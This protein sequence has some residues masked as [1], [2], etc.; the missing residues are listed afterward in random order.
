MS[1]MRREVL[2]CDYELGLDEGGNPLGLA[3]C[4]GLHK[5]GLP[6]DVALLVMEFAETRHRM[7]YRRDFYEEFT[8]LCNAVLVEVSHSIKE[9]AAYEHDLCRLAP[10]IVQLTCPTELPILSSLPSDRVCKSLERAVLRAP[11]L[12]A[13]PARNQIRTNQSRRNYSIH[14]EYDME[15]VDAL[16]NKMI[17]AGYPSGTISRHLKRLG[18]SLDVRVNSPNQVTMT[19]SEQVMSH[20]SLHACGLQL[21]EEQMHAA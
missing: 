12:P 2:E 16:R 20:V 13:G 1:V 10:G 15:A 3:S 11:Y 19:L 9:A 6:S 14:E 4:R 5:K 8:A 7:I 17:A 21:L 18:W